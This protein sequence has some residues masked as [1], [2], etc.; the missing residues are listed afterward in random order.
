MHEVMRDLDMRALAAI[1]GGAKG[2]WGPVMVALT[3]L[4]GGWATLAL[5]PLLGWTRTRRF[6]LA[7]ALAV[8]TQ[9]V[10]VWAIKAVVGRVRPWIAL[11][12]PPPL[13]APHDGSF[14]SGHASGSFCVAAFLAVTLPALPARPAAWQGAHWPGRLLA[15]ALLVLACLVAVSRVYLGAHFPSDVLAGA[16]FGGS[17]G[18]AA[19]SRYTSRGRTRSASVASQSAPASLSAPP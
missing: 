2:P 12:F 18:A 11:G 1:Y 16:L 15:M 14:P 8:A 4:G 17:I 5:V 9:A 13:G 6:A 7:L 19:G 3:I 10:G